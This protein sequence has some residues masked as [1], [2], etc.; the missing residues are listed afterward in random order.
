VDQR[1]EFL[2]LF[3]F[4]ESLEIQELLKRQSLDQGLFFL[5]QRQQRIRKPRFRLICQH[6]L[7]HLAFQLPDIIVEGFD[8]LTVLLPHTQILLNLGL[9]ETQLIFQQ[10][11][12]VCLFLIR[13]SAGARRDRTVR[14]PEPED[15]QRGKVQKNQDDN[16]EE[17]TAS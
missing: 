15:E 3:R 14:P 8:L 13:P 7:K 1:S 9:V 16:N 6:L 4:A 17:Q 5:G 12:N 10:S 11:F 2:A